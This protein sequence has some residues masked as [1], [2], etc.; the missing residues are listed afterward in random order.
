MEIADKAFNAWIARESDKWLDFHRDRSGELSTTARIEML[1]MWRAAWSGA[2]LAAIPQVSS[3]SVQH[4]DAA[5]QLNAH[6]TDAHKMQQMPSEGSYRPQ[7][8]RFYIGNKYSTGK[9]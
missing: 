6:Q 9:D 8:E 2:Q 1:R 7:H 3:Y 5:A 4:K